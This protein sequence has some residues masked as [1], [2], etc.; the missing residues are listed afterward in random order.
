MSIQ[1][2]ESA[3]AGHLSKKCL[4]R[5]RKSWRP[6]AE[7]G[8]GGAGDVITGGMKNQVMRVLVAL[9]T[10]QALTLRQKVIKGF[11]FV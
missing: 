1:T 7:Q 4:A 11:V 2:E 8:G 3:S 9:R 6:V 5:W 10:A